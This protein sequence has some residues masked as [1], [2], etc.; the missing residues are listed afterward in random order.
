[1]AALCRFERRINQTTPTTTQPKAR[2][3]KAIQ[4]HCVLLVSASSWLAAA[5][6]PAAAAPGRTTAT[7]DVSVTVVVS[8]CETVTVSAGRIFSIVSPGTVSVSVS[9]GRVTIRGPS[10]P[11]T[12]GTVLVSVV[13]RLAA[14]PPCA[15]STAEASNPS[16]PSVAMTDS[17]TKMRIDLSRP[18]LTTTQAYNKH[19]RRLGQ[20]P[21]ASL[22]VGVCL[23]ASSVGERGE[24]VRPHLLDRCQLVVGQLLEAG[25][26][27]LI[28]PRGATPTR[29]R[30][31]GRSPS[32]PVQLTVSWR[33]VSRRVTGARG[34]RCQAAL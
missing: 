34:G 14:R 25:E 8:V 10:E 17:C 16:S 2:I 33:A 11:V 4:P 13:A 23:P 29:V 5:A 28:N 18:P 32:N 9:V 26:E 19:R 7:A 20:P 15:T 1:M 3:P 24:L 12:V 27:P 21:G 31:R 30:R 22:V 6:A